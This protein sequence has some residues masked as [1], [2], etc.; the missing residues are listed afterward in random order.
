MAVGHTS[1][2]RPIRGITDPP[3]RRRIPAITGRRPQDT[4]RGRIMP[5]APARSPRPRAVAPHIRTPQTEGSADTRGIPTPH[6][7]NKTRGHPARPA[8]NLVLAVGMM[9]AQRA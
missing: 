1:M 4:H 7:T 6:H 9:D 8:A 3:N 2:A 5:P